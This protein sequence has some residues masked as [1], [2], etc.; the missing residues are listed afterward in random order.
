MYGLIHRQLKYISNV[1]KHTE[2]PTSTNIRIKA[3]SGASAHYFRE[4]EA[5]ILLNKQNI[6]Q[7]QGPRVR[8]PDNTVMTPTKHGHLPIPTL[9]PATTS[10][11]V[12]NKLRSASLVSVGQLCDEDCLAVFSKKYLH[13]FNKNGKVIINGS[14]NLQDGLWDVDLK[15]I[16]SL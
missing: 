3:D 12:Y 5:K 6:Q 4:E 11:H 14:R 16:P 1:K 13:I 15:P 2:D 8:L 9:S 10:T 7:Q